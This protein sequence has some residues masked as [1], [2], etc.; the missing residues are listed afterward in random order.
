MAETIH[1]GFPDRSRHIGAILARTWPGR[2]RFP[3]FN[4]PSVPP[5]E[6]GSADQH[7]TF[8]GDGDTAPVHQC[9]GQTGREEMGLPRKEQE[10]WSDSFADFE[11]GGFS[12]VRRTDF[13]KQE[14]RGPGAFGV[15][16]SLPG[17]LTR[18]LLRWRPQYP[19][20]TLCLPSS[21]EGL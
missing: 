8:P 9:T 5:G 20:R 3:F 18:I 19:L 21:P 10:L 1:F 2:D 4:H 14:S 11:G 12:S 13:P 6:Q 15:P 17:G 7:S 16:R